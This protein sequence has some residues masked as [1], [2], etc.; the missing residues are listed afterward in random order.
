MNEGF[1]VFSTHY[2]A[3]TVLRALIDSLGAL[4][5]LSEEEGTIFEVSIQHLPYRSTHLRQ[6]PKLENL[7]ILR[8]Y[9]GQSYLIPHWKYRI[10]L[11][12]RLLVSGP[13]EQV[14][15]FRAVVS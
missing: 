8:V 4:K 11:G 2:A 15:A 12:D 6:L 10:R 13:P 14:E 1:E 9:L 5:L 7:L 3:R